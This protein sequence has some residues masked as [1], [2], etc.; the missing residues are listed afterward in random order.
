MA[1]LRAELDAGLDVTA[2]TQYGETPLFMVANISSKLEIIQALLKAGADV[3]GLVR[4]PPQI[5]PVEVLHILETWI[6]SCWSSCFNG[7]P[8][9][10]WHRL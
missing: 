9:G 3:M 1:D 10:F 7:L 5:W 4:R 8:A 6:I 2:R